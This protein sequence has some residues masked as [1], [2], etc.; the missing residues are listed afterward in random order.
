[1]FFLEGVILFFCQK[2]RV[3]EIFSY[4]SLTTDI[5]ESIKKGQPVFLLIDLII[6]TIR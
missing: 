4:P 6:R 2:M 5:I 1:M 3:G